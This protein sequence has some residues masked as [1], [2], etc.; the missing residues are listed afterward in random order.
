MSPFS[1]SLNAV[2]FLYFSFAFLYSLLFASFLILYNIKLPLKHKSYHTFWQILLIVLTQSCFS[3]PRMPRTTSR[4]YFSLISVCKQL[5]DYIS[6]YVRTLHLKIYTTN[7][8][9]NFSPGAFYNTY[10]D[11]HTLYIKCARD[12]LY[13]KLPSNI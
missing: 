8:S 2:L 12:K 3:D 5:I 1:H 13:K 4:T 9:Q 11:V 7:D 10:T 6:C